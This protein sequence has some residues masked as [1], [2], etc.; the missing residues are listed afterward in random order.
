MH[1]ITII[2]SPTS[3]RWLLFLLLLF[4]LLASNRPLAVLYLRPTTQITTHVLLHN[5]CIPRGLPQS[6]S[7]DCM[8]H[9]SNIPYNSLAS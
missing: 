3:L 9:I 8:M 7:P 4:Q 6:P 1:L 5:L 2:A